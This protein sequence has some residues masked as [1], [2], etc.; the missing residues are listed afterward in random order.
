MGSARLRVTSISGCSSLRMDLSW[1]LPRPNKKKPCGRAH[2]GQCIENGIGFC[3]IRTLALL[4][5]NSLLPR[6]AMPNLHFPSW[7]NNRIG[8]VSAEIW[9]FHSR[10]TW[11]LVSAFCGGYL[12]WELLDSLGL[13][14]KSR[15]PRPSAWEASGGR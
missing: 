11:K 13:S 2:L 4:L 5:T 9:A 1:S 8:E 6:Q 3:Q 14:Q 15:R 7:Q 12:T 10:V